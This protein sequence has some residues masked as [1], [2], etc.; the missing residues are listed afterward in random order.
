EI[1]GWREAQDNLA[2]LSSN[3]SHRVADA[4]HEGLIDD[5]ASFAASVTAIGDVVTAI[6]TGEPVAAG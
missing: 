4:T 5:E 1:A 6:R 3:S 2:A